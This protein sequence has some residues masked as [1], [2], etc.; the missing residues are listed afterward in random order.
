M[1]TLQSLSKPSGSF[2]VTFAHQCCPSQV[3]MTGPLCFHLTLSPDVGCSG[4]SM[5]SE[6]ANHLQLRWSLKGLRQADCQGHAAELGSV[7]QGLDSAS[8]LFHAHHTQ[9]LLYPHSNL[10][11]DHFKPECTFSSI[12]VPL[13]TSLSLIRTYRRVTK[14]YLE[15]R[16][17]DYQSLINSPYLF[18]SLSNVL[19]TFRAC[20][21]CI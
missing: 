3:R 17:L 4:N 9:E 18:R 5:I 20:I 6:A 21:C 10:N 2:G 16:A 12:S 8:P 15:Y 1:Q 19:L 14:V 7:F 13:C 11:F